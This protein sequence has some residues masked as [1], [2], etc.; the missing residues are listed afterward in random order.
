MIIFGPSGSSEEVVSAK[1]SRKQQFEYLQ[2][3]GLTAYEHPFTFG[4]NI[5][6]NTQKELVE[7]FINNGIKLSIHAPY[8]INFA[9]QEPEKVKNTYKY[10]LDSVEKAREIG[11]DRVIFHPGSLTN[12][13]R[14]QAVENCLKNLK[15]FIKILDEKEIHDCYI[16]PETMGKHGQIGT[17]Q[18]VAQ[19]CEL[20]DR[21]IP[22]IDFGHINAF[23]LGSLDGEEK[24]D[25]IFDKFVNQLGKKEIHIHFSRI[26]FTSKG[27][28][29]HLTLDEE[30]EFGP[31][32][33]QMINSAQKFDAN[34]RIISESN[35][36]QTLDSN[37][38]KEYYKK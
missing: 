28:K 13:T 9:S 24:Y 30:S 19:M 25:E 35:G 15:E 7:H 36:T 17:W 4:V 8:Y 29:R 14:E 20:D 31:D 5:S 33:K 1:M 6:A 22:C 16:C 38:M 12:L 26:E 37:K 21:I 32:F 18:E 3:L 23:T 27:E 2:E 10:L 34:I 11:A